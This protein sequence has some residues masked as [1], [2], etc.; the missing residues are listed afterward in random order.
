MPT[1][2]PGDAPTPKEDLP[3]SI[4]LAGQGSDSALGIGS[5]LG[6]S[7]RSNGL[8]DLTNLRPN[9]P[10]EDP[11]ASPKPADA[12]PAALPDATSPAAQPAMKSATI[13]FIPGE[14]TIFFDDFSDMGADEVPAH[15]AAHDGKFEVRTREGIP[16]EMY[17]AENAALTSPPLIVPAN[18]TFELEW[19]GGGV[20]E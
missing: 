12:K 3:P 19:A 10:V 11:Y 6:I 9:G 16:P 4:R 14:R 18:F 1:S 2:S 15:W 8:G 20:M 5:T 7:V 17:A 13:E